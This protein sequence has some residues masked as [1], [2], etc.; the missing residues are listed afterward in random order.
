MKCLTPR[1]ISFQALDF[2]PLGATAALTAALSAGRRSNPR[3]ARA[4][5]ARAQRLQEPLLREDLEV[6]WLQL[7]ALP[8]WGVS[9]HGGS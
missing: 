3:A 9:I 1:P 5:P 2:R 8:Q 7:A 6:P 4:R